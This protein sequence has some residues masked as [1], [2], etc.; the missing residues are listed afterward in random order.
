MSNKCV[1]KSAEEFCNYANK[2]N[3]MASLH[4]LEVDYLWEPDDIEE[5]PK[6]PETSIHMLVKNFN[7][8]NICSIQFFN[9]AIDLE[10]IF[11]QFYRIDGDQR[12]VVM[13]YYHY[14]LIPMKFVIYE[15]KV[16]WLQCNVCEK[17]FHKRCF[18]E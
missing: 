15:G 9:L 7:K 6:I 2:V 16:E 4:L 13:N 5:G 10:P 8:D 1:I 12:I 11:T 3:G 18:L 14:R 17:Q